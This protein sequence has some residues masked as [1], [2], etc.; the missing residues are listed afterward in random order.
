MS[1]LGLVTT[2]GK[3]L[4]AQ[5]LAQSVTWCALGIGNWADKENPPLETVG[6]TELASEYGRKRIARVAY[7]E[8]D[9]DLG[10][11]TWNDHLYK[12]VAG[13]TP[14]TAFFTTFT[15][16]EAIGVSITEIG[17]FGGNVIT[18][19][20][21]FALVANVVQKGTLYWVQHRPVFAKTGRDTYEHIGIFEER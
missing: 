5:L 2:A 4:R 9:D 17:L 8:L 21:P 7:L 20:S 19:T 6:A 12:E 11:I 1:D 15:E 13:P 18:T 3:I 14:I 10:T 16:A